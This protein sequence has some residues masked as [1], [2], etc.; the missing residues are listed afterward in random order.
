MERPEEKPAE[1][2]FEPGDVGL[3]LWNPE[4]WPRVGKTGRSRQEQGWEDV[5]TGSWSQ[6]WSQQERI[7]IRGEKTQHWGACQKSEVRER[8]WPQHEDC[9]HQRLWRTR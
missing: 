5:Q 1:T 8:R 3:W 7:Q 2:G 4:C 6:P 9:C